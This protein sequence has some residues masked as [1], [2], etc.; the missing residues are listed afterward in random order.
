[1]PGARPFQVVSSVSCRALISLPSRGSAT[2]AYGAA[3]ASLSPV[4]LP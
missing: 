3:Q 4:L 2:N 1:M